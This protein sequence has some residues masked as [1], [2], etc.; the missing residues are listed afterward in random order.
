MQEPF[1]KSHH[2]INNHRSLPADGGLHLPDQVWIMNSTS[3]DSCHSQY[4]V[5]TLTALAQEADNPRASQPPV[6][7]LTCSPRFS[8]K[9]PT[10]EDFYKA[11]RVFEEESV[12]GPVFSMLVGLW[13][14]LSRR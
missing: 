7:N 2:K 11:S 6:L 1:A 13:G 10:A 14:K 9:A 12:P 5:S 8:F 3:F 4:N